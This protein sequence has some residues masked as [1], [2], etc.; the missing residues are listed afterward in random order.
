MRKNSVLADTPEGN[1]L[2]E[3]LKG[4]LDRVKPELNHSE[5][6]YLLTNLEYRCRERCRQ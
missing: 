6:H 1:A 3:Q 4:T 5:K 2:L